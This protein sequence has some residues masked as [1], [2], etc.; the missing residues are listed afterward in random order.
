[1]ESADAGGVQ[2][3][4]FDVNLYHDFATAGNTHGLFVGRSA[5]WR[6]TPGRDADVS[7]RLPHALH[8]CVIFREPNTGLQL[9]F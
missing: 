9:A 1:M 5:L 3:Q 6:F 2:D 7:H 4:H 8:L